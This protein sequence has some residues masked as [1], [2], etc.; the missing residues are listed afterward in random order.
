MTNPPFGSQISVKGEAKLKEFELGYQWKQKNN[1]FYKTKIAQEKP[2]QELFI[3]RCL[4]MLKTGGKLAII[5]PET[6]LH[7]P[8]KKYIYIISN[9]TIT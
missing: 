1:Y 3:E 5:L 4:Q 6:Y 8:S 7:A 9:K 2:P